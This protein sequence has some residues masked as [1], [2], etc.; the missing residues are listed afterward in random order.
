[1]AG[2]CALPGRPGVIFSNSKPAELRSLDLV[3]YA[4]LRHRYNSGR[5]HSYSKE[6]GERGIRS[7]EAM[8][9][10]EQFRY[11]KTEASRQGRTA[12]TAIR[13]NAWCKSLAGYTVDKFTLGEFIGAGRIGYVYK[14]QFSD[15]PTAVRAV[16]LTFDSLKEGWEV[17]LK[18]VMSLGLVDGVVHFHHAGPAQINHAGKTRLCHFTVWD[19]IEPGENLRQ[20][21]ARVKT[22]PV[23]FLLAV[24][25]KILRVLHACEA[26]GVV[27]H[28]DLHAGNIL[29]GT[30]SRARLDDSLEPRAPIYV[31]DFGY[32]ATGGITTPKDDYQGLSVII[33]EMIPRVEYATATATHRQILQAMKRDLGKL[34]TEATG[35]ERRPPLELLK[36]LVEIRRMAQAGP[37]AGPVAV[38]TSPVGMR[39]SMSDAPSV[40]QFQV[41]E[42]IGERWEWW[43]RLFVPTVPARSK[44]LA[45][46][47]PT[48]V[49]G[50]RGCGKTMLFRRLSERLIIECGEVAELPVQDRFAALYVN[51]NDFA[52]A[53]ARFP[54]HPS[55]EE[56]ARLVCY[57]NLCILGDLLTVQ[58]ARAGRLGETT[59][60]ALLGLV[61]RWLVPETFNVLVVGEDRLERYRAILEQHKWSFPSSKAGLFPGYAE[62]AQHRW[63]PRFVQQVRECCPWMA[64]R[65]ILLFVD[66]FS[67]PRVSESMQRVLNRVFL[68]R[69]PEFL[70]KVATEAWTTFIPEDSSGKNL[71][72]GDDYQLVDMGEESL[73]LPD[74]E[75]LAFLRAV[76]SRRLESDVRI[77]E[78]KASLG[79]LFGRLNLSKTEFARR[80]RLTLQEQGEKTIVTG[81]S[82]R[83]GRSRGRV[84]YFGEDVFANLWSGDTRTMIQLVTDVI[85]QASEAGTRIDKLRPIDTPVDPAIQDRAFRNRGGEW[86][87]SHTRNEPTNPGKVKTEVERLKK[88]RTDYSL[89]GTYGDH[90]KAVVE[91]FVAAATRLLLGPTYTI[92]EGTSRRE[93]PRMAFRIEIIDEFRIDGL[94]QEI[95]RDL[96][97]YGLFMRDNRGK[98]VRGAFVPRLYLR[99]LL[100]PFATL[101]LSK[102]DSVPLTSSEFTQ[103]LLEPDAFKTRFVTHRFDEGQINLPFVQRGAETQ[104]DPAYDD[105]DEG[106]HGGTLEETSEDGKVVDNLNEEDS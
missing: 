72:D 13:D 4:S 89:S 61:Q 78:G 56:E 77:S 100:L 35:T 91:A 31:S 48:V 59:P 83:R 84:Q 97:R 23:S 12:V 11:L 3:T 15:V 42:M 40:G 52:D 103:L 28:G 39:S 5:V 55:A 86:L 70:A 1:M 18:K 60:D 74:D 76:F 19:F 65:A 50:P 79:A 106:D 85:D 9:E 8:T 21:L 29:I 20:Y 80:L 69:S 22:I 57:A 71:Q 62:L 46:D 37:L 49:T 73:F 67:T 10:R 17:E 43:K 45:L 7:K 36:H 101:A 93:V 95:Y 105:L 81:S 92:R 32:G 38:S 47:I 87:N 51:A 14:A 34:L 33:N 88:I 64:G 104:S 27:R 63:L 25:E 96:I 26:E 41:S 66:D 68:Q 58:S 53:F 30:E 90:L 16:K 6:W 82:Q 24:V 54:E 99:R 2:S 94:A 102:R 44:I 98:S 75:R